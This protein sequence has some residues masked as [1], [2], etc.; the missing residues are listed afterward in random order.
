MKFQLVKASTSVILTV[1]IRNSSVT[2]GAGLGS[3]DHTSSITGGYVKRNGTGVALAVDEDVGT[4]GTYQ[5]PSAAA[6]VRIG[7][8]ANMPTGAYELHFH[9]DLF[10]TADWVTIILSGASNMVPLAIEIQLTSVNVNDAVRGGMTALPNANAAASGGLFTRGTGAGQINQGANG[11]IDVDMVAIHGTSLTE[12]SGQLAAAFKKFFD[13]GTPT[14]TINSL[15]DAVAGATGG[16]FIAGSN[17]ATSITT[18]LTA[19]I[20]G[21]ITGNLSGS[22][23]TLTGHTV[24]T[25]DSF[26]RIGATGSGLTSLAPAAGVA[27]ADGAITAAKIA[28]NA[29]TAA[30]FATGAIAADEIAAAAC[31]K[32]ADHVHRRTNANVEASANGDAVSIRSAYGATAKLTNKVAISG[33][34]LTIYK[35]DDNTALGTQAV[36]TDE[37]AD[38]V[39]GLDTV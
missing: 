20:V 6:K 33:S 35:A 1:F 31:N 22:V 11:R 16:V 10:T 25:G 8:P 34:I 32:I 38:P 39:T 15:P 26:G 29:F 21:N 14:G 24:Q 37:D 13:V 2:T 17:A 4:E 28:T 27:L 12:T 19:N 30:K 9:N 18:A 3:L 5:A 7:T 23:G 36:T